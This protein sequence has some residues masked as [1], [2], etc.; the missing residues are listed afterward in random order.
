MKKKVQIVLVMLFL[1]TSCQPGET[2]MESPKNTD[3]VQT[4]IDSIRVLNKVSGVQ[5]CTIDSAGIV[6]QWTSG[7]KDNKNE[8]LIANNSSLRI[9]STT[10]LF[11]AYL[12]MKLV[13]D[14][15]IDLE[16]NLAKWYPD[17]PN[18]EQISI[19]NL[20]MHKSG[21][22]EILKF[23]KFLMACVFN[24]TKMYDLNELIAFISNKGQK[25]AKKPN[26]IYEYSNTNYILLG[27]IA[28]KICQ[29]NFGQL[30][31]S[32]SNEIKLENTSYVTSKNAAT[33]INGYDKDLIPFPWTYT[34]KPNNTSWTSLAAS[35]GGIISNAK[36][37]TTFFDY[38]VNGNGLNSN[39]K[40]LIFSFEACNHDNSA[41]IEGI[42][43]GVF[44]IR[45]NGLEYWGHEGQMIG[46]ESLVLY[47]PSTK[48]VFCVTGNRSAFKG[49]YQL[50]AKVNESYL[51]E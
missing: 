47:C 38:F 4:L 11:T 19:R 28:E 30:I 5:F 14:A 32:L 6:K 25:K 51:I 12:I 18:A 50:I 29:K 35:S 40:S 15:L 45:I 36:D 17:F 23:P 10:K 34:N 1:Y 13:Q 31:D 27:G 24:P 44:Q 20:L 39:T 22:V 8:E 48:R 46:S 3:K 37:L 33:L 9:G 7:F 26:E 16:D 42:G 41:E 21:A 2:I 43:L 49:K